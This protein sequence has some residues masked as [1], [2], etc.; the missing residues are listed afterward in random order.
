MTGAAVL[1]IDQGTTNTKAI[2]V[3]GAGTIVERG[4]SPVPIRHPRPG[5]VEQDADSIW[6]SVLEA[7]DS[8]LNA[9]PVA[10]VGISNQR[11]SV[12][13][14]DRRTGEPVGPVVTWQ[15]RR[16]TEACEALKA[17]GLDPEIME[18]TGLPLDPL[19]PAL[20]I[21]WLLDNMPPGAPSPESG[22]LCAGTIDSWLLFR[23]T[24][25][26][27]HACD[28]SNAARTQL[29]DLRSLA[30]SERLC[31]LFDIPPEILPEVQESAHRFGT[32]VGVPG[33]PD[34]TPV[35]SAIGDSHAALFGHAAFQPG[36][37]KAT[38]G[39]GSS[40]MATV[41]EFRA[42]Q[43]GITTTVAWAA[44]GRTTF[45]FEGNILVSASILPWTASLLGLDGDVDAL[46]RLAEDVPDCAGVTLVPALV[47]LGAP[48]WAPA[49]RGIV[50]GLSFAADRRHV[51][52]AAAESIALQ[53]ADVLRAVE[54]QSP[55]PP[56][57][58]F[59]DGGPSRNAFLMGL[60]ADMAGHTLYQR[61]APDVSALGAAHLAGLDVGIWDGLEALGALARPS[62]RVTPSIGEDERL[63]RL[64]EWWAALARCMGGRTASG[65]DA[66]AGSG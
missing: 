16:T 62:R 5:W 15:C 20:K 24:G 9:A 61:D 1:A 17:E 64:E 18:A 35:A 60:V 54:R 3:D 34:G 47:G 45:A 31:D 7:M 36:D 65:G 52:R 21:R 66:S 28:R 6:H 49:A 42:P 25:G 11:E 63:A 33:L 59:V 22:D 13:L 44:G 48:Y 29:F 10:A 4:N 32:T 53:I 39:T 8:C 41:P 12:V 30:W 57:R 43:H 46:M 14:W 56:A 38:F 23:L 51:A 58:V 50:T 27:V 55:S 2:L 37:A 19:F 40:V 26:A